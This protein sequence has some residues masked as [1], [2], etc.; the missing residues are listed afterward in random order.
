MGVCLLMPACERRWSSCQGKPSRALAR[1]AQSRQSAPQGSAPLLVA[2]AG[3]SAVAGAEGRG[4]GHDSDRRRRRGL[5][6]TYSGYRRP[7]DG[8][9]ARRSAPVRCGTATTAASAYGPRRVSAEL[10]REK[11]GGLRIGE[12]GVWRVLR[13]LG[14]STR[15]KR[16]A[17]IARHHDPYERRPDPPPPERHINAS[18]PGEKVQLDCFYVGRLSGTKGTVWQY[19]GIDVASAFCW[20]ELHTSERNPPLGTRASC[21]IASPAS[22]PRRAGSSAK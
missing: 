14:L 9:R 3:R 17:L 13:R 12:H 10:A 21:C 2:Q 6:V 19:T 7:A 20:A 18:R 1:C 11:W 4:A 5:W 8:R 16:L 15:G 22:W